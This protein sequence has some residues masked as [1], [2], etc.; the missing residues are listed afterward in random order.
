MHHKNITH[1][2]VTY[3]T[4]TRNADLYKCAWSRLVLNEHPL[5]PTQLD[6]SMLGLSIMCMIKAGPQWT[7]SNA[8]STWYQHAR[9]QYHVLAQ[10]APGLDEIWV[11]RQGLRGFDV[12]RGISSTGEHYKKLFDLW[13]FSHD[14]LLKCHKHTPICDDHNNEINDFH[15]PRANEHGSIL[16]KLFIFITFHSICIGF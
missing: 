11:L 2:F 10:V 9:P 5:M 16:T 1:F 4:E 14:V 8:N 15:R 13:W 3:Q 6:I 7:S 12:G